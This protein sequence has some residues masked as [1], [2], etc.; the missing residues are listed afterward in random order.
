MNVSRDNDYVQKGW[1]LVHRFSLQ[2]GERYS[3]NEV[4]DKLNALKLREAGELRKQFGSLRHMLKADNTEPY[5]N[6][7]ELREYKEV[8]EEF[9]RRHFKLMTPAAYGRVDEEGVFQLQSHSDLL[10]HM[11][12]VF[13]IVKKTRRDGMT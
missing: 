4:E 12:G 6:L 5:G 3:E 9:E 7:F 13:S 11:R 8:K 10:H 2:G 1:D